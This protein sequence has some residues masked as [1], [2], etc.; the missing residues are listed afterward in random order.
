MQD[1]GINFIHA[2]AVTYSQLVPK[3]QPHVPNV[4]HESYPWPVG[5]SKPIPSAPSQESKRTRRKSIHQ[6]RTECGL[7][8]SEHKQRRET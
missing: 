6:N 4:L 1:F 2:D 5:I 7:D 8:A 3:R